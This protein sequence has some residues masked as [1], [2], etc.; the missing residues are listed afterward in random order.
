MNRKLIFSALG[1]IIVLYMSSMGLSRAVES[2]PELV[3]EEYLV[4]PNTFPDIG[5]RLPTH[6]PKSIRAKRAPWRIPPWAKSFDSAERDRVVIENSTYTL[7]MT[8][9]TFKNLVFQRSYTI[10]NN[11]KRVCDFVAHENM[12]VGL[13]IAA[14]FTNNTDWILEY[15]GKNGIGNVLRN[16]NSL[17]RKKGYR[18]VFKYR[19]IQGKP[20]YFFNKDGHYGFSYNDQELPYRYDEIV[21]YQCCEG[22]LYSPRVN[23]YMAYFYGKRGASW[24]YVEAGIYTAITNSKQ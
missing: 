6:A 4:P 16:G 23:D 2:V 13:S 17:G 11:G 24:Y 15:V 19:F 18:E 5:P 9:T 22:G 21:H 3:V 12:I 20:F 8:S 14:F 7:K 1:I 10:F